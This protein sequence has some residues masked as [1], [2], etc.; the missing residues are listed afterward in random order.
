MAAVL[1]VVGAQVEQI[2]KQS[3]DSDSS[4]SES[5]LPVPKRTNNKTASGRVA[6]RQRARTSRADNEALAKLLD[7][8]KETT[9]IMNAQLESPITRAVKLFCASPCFEDLG[10][11]NKMLASKVLAN[12]GRAHSFIATPERAQRIMISLWLEE[13]GCRGFLSSEHDLKAVPSL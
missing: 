8:M 11:K 6:K 2:S 4:D 1:A 9:R 3:D 12:E 5:P 10:T 13:D 7:V